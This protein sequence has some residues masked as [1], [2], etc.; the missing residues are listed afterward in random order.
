MIELRIDGKR[1]P[2]NKYVRDVFY[3]ILLA[4]ISTLKGIPV[5]WKEIELR[6]KRE[7]DEK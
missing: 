1:V 2:M 4:L 7:E 3:K 6:V 5:D